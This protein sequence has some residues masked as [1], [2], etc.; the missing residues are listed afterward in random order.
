MIL[1]AAPAV[2]T[3]LAWAADG[4]A[5]L[6]GLM[7]RLGDDAFRA[8]SL[9]P[10]WT[11]AHVLTHIARNADAM[12]NLLTWARTGVVTPAYA[13]AEARAA[14]IEKGAVRTPGEIRDDLIASSDRLAQAVRELPDAAWAALVTN[15]Q[16]HVMRASAIPWSR[17]KEMWIHSVDLDAGASFADMPTPMMNALLADAVDAMSRKPDCPPLELVDGNHRWDVGESDTRI[18]VTGPAAE[19]AAWLLGR[20]KGKLLR[21]DGAR[22]LPALPRWL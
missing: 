10:N 17:A 6:R 22:K 4:A 7:T 18:V 11:R 2:T 20:S 16:G 5:H 21:A 3:S 1:P 14:D 15:V 19:L 12:I 9:L 13:S 8:P